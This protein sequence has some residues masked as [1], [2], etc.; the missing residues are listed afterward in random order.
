MAGRDTTNGPF[1]GSDPNDWKYSDTL[2]GF[3]LGWY[4][5][6]ILVAI[7]GPVLLLLWVNGVFGQ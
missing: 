1:F 7:V 2:S 6:A 3:W 5:V 4:L